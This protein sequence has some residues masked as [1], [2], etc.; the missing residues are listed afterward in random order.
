MLTP[1][2]ITVG[3]RVCVIGV[4]A[5]DISHRHSTI[6]RLTRT[7]IVMDNGRRFR[8]DTWQNSIPRST[9]G[10]HT[11]HATCQRPKEVDTPS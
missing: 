4:G 10:G 1:E 11:L 8:R 9:W 2:Q 7:T 6:V 5:D 3:R